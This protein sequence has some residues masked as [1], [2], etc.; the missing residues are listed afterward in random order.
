M[1]NKKKKDKITS[2]IKLSKI[3]EKN[4]KAAGVLFDAGLHCIGC[5]MAMQETLEQ[6]CQAHGM[7]KNEIDKIIEEL[8]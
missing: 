4:P 8:N 1:K 2:D 5:P 7:S 3:L 6:G